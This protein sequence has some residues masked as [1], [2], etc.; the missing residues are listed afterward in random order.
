MKSNEMLTKIPPD[1]E[2]EEE[3]K[4]DDDKCCSIAITIRTE[5]IEIRTRV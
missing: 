2:Q 3:K 4:K 5:I 1:N